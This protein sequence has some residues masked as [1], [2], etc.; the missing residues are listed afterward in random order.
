[1]GMAVSML[2]SMVFCAFDRETDNRST[3]TVA[4]FVGTGLG[5]SDTDMSEGQALRKK[6][7]N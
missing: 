7:A 1:M 6:H 3:G 4:G 2:A 5:K